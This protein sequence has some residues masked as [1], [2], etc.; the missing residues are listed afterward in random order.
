MTQLRVETT[1]ID[2]LLLL[3]LPVYRDARGWFKEN[4]QR[5][6]MVALGLPDFQ[7]VQNN[8]SFN[9]TAGVTRGLH[10][11]PWDKLVSV[12]SGR[13]FCAW[14][15]LRKGPGFGSTVTV[16]LDESR[17]A[18][19][20]AGVA[21]SYQTLTDSVAYSYL[22]NRHWS[23]E[24]VDQYSYLNL[25]DETVAIEWPIPLE[26]AK[27][28]DQDLGHPRLADVRPFVARKTLIIGAGGQLGRALVRRL[29]DADAVDSNGL[30]IASS[31]ALAAWPWDDYDVVINASAWTAVDDAETGIGRRS[32]WE[33]N[34]VGVANLARHCSAHQCTLVH[35]STDYVFDGESDRPWLETDAMAPLGAYGQSKAAGDIAVSLVEKHYLMR[36]SWLIGDGRNFCTI[37]ADL[38]DR[39][40]RPAVVCDQ[41]GRL[42][43]ADNLAAAIVHLLETA[44]DYGTYNCTDGGE[45]VTWAD[46][47]EAV[48]A[49][50]GRPGEVQPVTS[51]EYFA[52]RAVAPRPRYSV[53]DLSKLEA[54]GY[55]VPIYPLESWGS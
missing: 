43:H 35:V 13:V 38:A 51:E 21:N 45:P 2:G 54:T 30:D 15:D 49:A 3:D 50:R 17:A 46:V 8:V 44:A 19:V 25:A 18:F 11:E 33:V 6:K 42:T 7:P 55:R 16:E 39:G 40:V 31:D 1:D 26:H 28:S 36:T 5:K 34:A 23:A 27:V 47:A 22:V 4:W 32:A 24:L 52:G 20:P 48:F 14:V 53:L 10:A 12:T 9:A 29:P 41:V 37:M